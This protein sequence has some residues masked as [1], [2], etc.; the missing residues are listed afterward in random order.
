MASDIEN[1]QFD[2][3]RL[4]LLFSVAYYDIPDKVKYTQITHT[5]KKRGFPKFLAEI[6]EE[7]IFKK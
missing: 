3:F 2:L 6:V 4:K 5:F 1:Q 7:N